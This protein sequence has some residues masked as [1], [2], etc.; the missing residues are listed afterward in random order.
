MRLHNVYWDEHSLGEKEGRDVK[1]NAVALGRYGPKQSCFLIPVRSDYDAEPIENQWGVQSSRTGK[2]VLV[3][4]SDDSPGTLLYLSS[5]D[6]TGKRFGRLFL[7]HDQDNLAHILSV[8]YGIGGTDDGAVTWED[9]LFRVTGPARF[10][11]NYVSGDDA[12]LTLTDGKEVIHDIVGP[13]T[14]HERLDS[15]L[16]RIDDPRIPRWHPNGQEK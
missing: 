9:A 11:I 5:F 6:R 10:V 1:I 13:I 4:N 16:L 8:G 12:I 3:A 15:D 7:A 2:P 14:L